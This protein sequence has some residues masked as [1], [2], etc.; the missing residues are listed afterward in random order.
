MSIKPLQLP[1]WSFAGLAFWSGQ[2]RP[3]PLLIIN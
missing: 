1:H 2:S 3:G